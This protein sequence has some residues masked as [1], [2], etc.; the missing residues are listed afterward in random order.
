MFSLIGTNTTRGLEGGEN[1]TQTAPITAT[2]AFWSTVAVSHNN[3]NSR[4]HVSKT[5]QQQLENI[6][7]AN[8]L[9]PLADKRPLLGWGRMLGIRSNWGQRSSLLLRRL[10]GLRWSCGLE[11]PSPSALAF[12]VRKRARPKRS[13]SCEGLSH[14]DCNACTLCGRCWPCLYYSFAEGLGE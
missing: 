12:L 11:R 8:K 5:N 4:W 6:I 2:H 7:K 9:I 14:L 13:G 1:L 3:H 10:G